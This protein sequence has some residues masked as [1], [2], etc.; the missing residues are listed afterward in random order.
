MSDRRGDLENFEIYVMDADGGNLRNLTNNRQDDYSPSW[1][2]DGERIA[3]S[4]NRDGDF[5]IYV[6]D[7]DGGNLR[8]LTDN[9]RQDDDGPAW[10]DPAFAVSPAGKTLTMWRWLKQ[11]DR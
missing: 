8:N 7:A 9:N 2:P 4:S 5:E 3:F 1:S 6:M 10:F 11:V